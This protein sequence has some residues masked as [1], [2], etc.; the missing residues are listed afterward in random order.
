MP[1]GR[2]CTGSTWPHLAP[3]IAGLAAA[4]ILFPDRRPA[5]ALGWSRDWHDRRAGWMHMD[6][7]TKAPLQLSRVSG[8]QEGGWGGIMAGMDQEAC[9]PVHTARL[10]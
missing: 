5:G 6:G 2:Y 8:E 1:N 4:G 3:L 10:T 9:F 7:H